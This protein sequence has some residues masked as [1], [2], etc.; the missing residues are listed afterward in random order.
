MV[1]KQKIML[2]KRVRGPDAQVREQLIANDQTT[3]YKKAKAPRQ[4]SGC[5]HLNGEAKKKCETQAK[6]TR[7]RNARKNPQIVSM[8]KVKEFQ[9]LFYRRAGVTPEWLKEDYSK[10]I[11]NLPPRSRREIGLLIDRRVHETLEAVDNLFE[12]MNRAKVI[13]KTVDAEDIRN[14]AKFWILG[15][16]SRGAV[17]GREKRRNLVGALELDKKRIDANELMGKKGDV[18]REYLYGSKGKEMKKFS[19]AKILKLLKDKLCKLRIKQTKSENKDGV[20][21]GDSAVDQLAILIFNML[22]VIFDALRQHKG[23]RTNIGKIVTNARK[24]DPAFDLLIGQADF[25]SATV[26]A[27]KDDF[28]DEIKQR[29]AAEAA[30]KK[31]RKADRRAFT[32]KGNSLRRKRKRV[33]RAKR[34]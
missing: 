4:P 15:P 29:E 22:R 10:K 18:L 5:G 7:T 3:M 25:G 11:E 33:R 24:Y 6:A 14:G 27:S 23:K 1:D 31:K 13:R 32:G 21:M 9:R 28:A 17:Y 8:Y 19:R 2:R 34:G 16:D 30:A 20:V 12:L 26:Q